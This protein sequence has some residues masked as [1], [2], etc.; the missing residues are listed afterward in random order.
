MR[1]IFAWLVLGISLWLPL[2][3]VITPVGAVD[4]ID[5]ACQNVHIQALKPEERPAV[6]RDNATNAKSNPIFGP[7]GILTT[8]VNILSLIA[9]VIAVI[10]ILIGGIKMITS[11]GDSNSVASARRTVLYAVISLIVVGSAQAA[12]RFILY[13]LNI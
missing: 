6:C 13:K 12:V 2:G 10:V 7:G 11:S 5:P 3:G 1:R 9:G 8:V 4:V